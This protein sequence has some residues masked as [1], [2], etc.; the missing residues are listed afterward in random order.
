MIAALT[1]METVFPFLN[2]EFI[3]VKINQQSWIKKTHNN[4]K[5]ENGKCFIRLSSLS[6]SMHLQVS[7]YTRKKEPC[8]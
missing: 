1:S 2:E 6:A 3:D 4:P 8:S 5:H 7:E